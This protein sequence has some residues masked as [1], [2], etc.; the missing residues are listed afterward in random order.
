MRTINQ[1]DLL[2]T[3]SVGAYKLDPKENQ[4]LIIRDICGIVQVGVL[5]LL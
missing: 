1:S 4:R 5:G 3:S 2:I